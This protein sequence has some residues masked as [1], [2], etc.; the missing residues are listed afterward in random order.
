MAT[1]A[2]KPSGL[3]T[4]ISPDFL[5]SLSSVETSDQR[6]H[7]EHL[8]GNSIAGRRMRPLEMG[9]GLQFYTLAHMYTHTLTTLQAGRAWVV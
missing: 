1:V 3:E 8:M 6:Q 9:R 2:T 7:L 5:T 4:F